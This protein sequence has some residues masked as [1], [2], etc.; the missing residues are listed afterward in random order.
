MYRLSSITGYV[1]NV[2]LYEGA[3][4]QLGEP[5]FNFPLIAQYC[6]RMSGFIYNS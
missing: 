4:V 5:V 1:P 6:Y 3:S 2:N